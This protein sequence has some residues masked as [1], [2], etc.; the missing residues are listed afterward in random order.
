MSC[1]R[2]NPNECT[3]VMN[4][5]KPASFIVLVMPN[6]FAALIE[7]I[8][9]PPELAR[10]RI[11]ALEACA[12]SRKEEK[13]DAASGCFTSPNTLPPLDVMTWVVSLSSEVPNA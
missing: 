11:C 4:I 8:V 3:S 2:F 5:N 13:S 6:S 7:L 1:V 9:S 12:W 10:P